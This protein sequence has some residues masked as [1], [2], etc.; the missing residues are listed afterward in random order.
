[1]LAGNVQVLGPHPSAGTPAP[2]ILGVPSPAFVLPQ[3]A[4][5][6]Q[7]PSLI[8]DE[9]IYGPSIPDNLSYPRVE[10]TYE[11]SSVKYL[12]SMETDPPILPP[13]PPPANPSPIIGRVL[14]FDSM[15]DAAPLQPC[16]H[17]RLEDTCSMEIR[18]DS[19]DRMVD[20]PE[21]EGLGTSEDPT[22]L[23]AA[24]RNSSLDGCKE[25]L[26]RRGSSSDDD[27]DGG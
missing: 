18:P 9:A 24:L 2:T 7:P 22:G 13:S 3:G 16:S 14:G 26:P 19:D 8:P 4:S 5:R 17:P 6:S 25:V 10:D 12:S 23:E 27:E 21:S 20:V 1:L 15:D 11:M